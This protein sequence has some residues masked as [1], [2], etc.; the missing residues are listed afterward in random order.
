MDAL[1][2][3]IEIVGKFLKRTRVATNSTVWY[4]GVPRPLVVDSFKV[5]VCSS[6][7]VG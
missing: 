1:M 5:C 4:F 3:T 7:V 2:L 6:T